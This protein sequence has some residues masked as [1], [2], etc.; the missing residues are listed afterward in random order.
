[1]REAAFMLIFE[2]MFRDDSYDE[3]I[4]SAKA[5]DEYEFN[6]EA[7]QLFINVCN[8]ETELDAVISEFS[9]TRSVSRIGKVS[10]AV[11]RIAV[12][13]SI[14]TDIPVNI[15]VSEAVSLSEKYSLETDTKFVNGLLGAFARSEKVP[16]DKRDSVSPKA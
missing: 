1:M 9:T 16:A 12:Y 5:A 4:E 11:I 15:A 13:E 14:Y 2:K 7:Q 3:I 8:N 10:L 6:E